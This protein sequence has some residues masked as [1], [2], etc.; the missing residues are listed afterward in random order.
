MPMNATDASGEQTSIMGANQPIAFSEIL[1]SWSSHVTVGM[2][3]RTQT[4]PALR[5][6]TIAR[7][8]RSEMAVKS[9]A[10]T[11]NQT[12]PLPT[13]DGR[14]LCPS[15]FVSG[16]GSRNQGEPMILT[17]DRSG[18]CAWPVELPSRDQHGRLASVRGG[19]G[20]HVTACGHPYRGPGRGRTAVVVG[21]GSVASFETCAQRVGALRG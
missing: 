17:E 12:D 2:I 14:W 5:G 19:L 7:Q 8:P 11:A 6:V 3:L 9:F 4:E 16:R 18:R 1:A 10:R 15:D 13:D 20:N 21:G